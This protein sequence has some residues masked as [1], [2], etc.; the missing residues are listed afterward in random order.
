MYKVWIYIT[1][2]IWNNE[3]SYQERIALWS[4]DESPAS[5]GKIFVPSLIQG[6]LDDLKEGSEIVFEEV[7]NNKLISCTWLKHFIKASLFAKEGE[8][9]SWI[10]VY[11]VDNHNH[12]LTFRNECRVNIGKSE[13]LI[14]VHIDQHADTK[15]NNEELKIE[16]WEWNEIENFVNTKTN[17]GNFITAAINSWIIKKVIQIRTD[18]ALQHL[19]LSIS[20]PL[21]TIVDIDIDFRVD[22]EVTQ[23]DIDIIRRL[24]KQAKLVT[25]ATSPYFIDQKR[26]I[27]IVKRILQ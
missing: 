5:L 23:E 8:G 27:E 24:I 7:V 26:A 17:V 2:P 25:I 6:N 15:E 13:H 9:D 10:P 22:K 19:N 1:D 21:N 20:Q 4:I 11:I 3:F 12:A 16:N 14:V 18:Y